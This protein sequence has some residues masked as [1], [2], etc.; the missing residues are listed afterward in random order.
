[1]I[2]IKQCKWPVDG[3]EP[4]IALMAAKALKV[5]REELQHVT[6]R[7][8]SIDARKN[9]EIQYV[10]ELDVE[11]RKEDRIL[12]K[13]K[14]GNVT[15]VDVRPY[16]FPGQCNGVSTRPVVIG[17][18]P[19]GLFCAYELAIHGFCPILIERGEPV[20]DRTRT[21]EH[22]WKTGELDVE[23]NVQ[24][25]EGGAGA[26]SDGK[27][28]T[29]IK[30]VEGR[31]REVLQTFVNFGADPE[32]LYVN[33]PHIGTDVLKTVISHMRKAI[34]AA[35]GEILFRTKVVDFVIEDE[36][37]KKR[38]KQLVLLDQ[39]TQKT[40]MLSVDYVV[41]AIGHS[42]R[43]TFEV[44]HKAE[45]PMEAKAFA[46]GVRMQ[47]PQTFINENQY[48]AAAAYLPAA[49]YKITAKAQDGRGVYSFCMCPGGFVVD[50][51]SEP[52]RL[53]VN[54]MSYHARDGVNANSAIIVSVTPEDYPGEG[55]LAGVLF[56]RD[57]E[58][59]A[60][61]TGSGRVPIQRWED[62][63]NNRI[64]TAFDTISPM[65]KGRT[66]SANLREVL[67]HAISQALLD[68]MPEFDRKIPGFDSPDVV[69]AAV[70][71]RTSS[72]V[73]IGRDEHFE[74]EVRGLFPCGEGAGY[75]GGIM[76]GAVDGIRIAEELA[77]RLTKEG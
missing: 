23:S 14:N 71:S 1:M 29:L 24:F 32:I 72:P 33:K 34:L 35:G 3:G 67:P 41:L 4:N 18:G 2:R 37:T 28:T 65:I 30:D 12:K 73:R 64:S 17:M 36:S 60:F 22:F 75:A 19:A 59:R 70:E 39:K 43:D 16:R 40:R 62:F 8:R 42:A 46:V 6:I 56:Q 13:C 44:L 69:L 38:L 20:E 27:L 31:G 10:Y 54:G 53:A 58:E 66:Q 11:I 45:V 50:A 26:F 25:G 5:P 7:K 61:V 63:K 15:K 52:G 68:A 51:S 76:S 49:D 47:H 55:P 21:V 9:K 74:S 57:L 77:K 48:G